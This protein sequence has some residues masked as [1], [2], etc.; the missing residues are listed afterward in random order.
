MVISNNDNS[1]KY[2]TI[3]NICARTAKKIDT[4]AYYKHLMIKC[5]VKKIS[6]YEYCS[7]LTISDTK[8]TVQNTPDL[9][10]TLSKYL[11]KNDVAMY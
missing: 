9:C 6:H 8:T 5:L 3:A 2:T 7:F 4:D 1:N 11:Y 10:A